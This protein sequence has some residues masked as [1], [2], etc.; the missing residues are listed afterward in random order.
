MKNHL[1]VTFVRRALPVFLNAKGN[2]VLC[3]L[4]HYGRDLMTFSLGLL[5]MEELRHMK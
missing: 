3:E 2:A 1:C 4:Y 5:M